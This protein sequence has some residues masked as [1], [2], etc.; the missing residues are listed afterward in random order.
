MEGKIKNRDGSFLTGCTTCGKSLHFLYDT[1]AGRIVLKLLTRRF[2]SKLTGVY[3][4]SR[5]S[6]LNIKSAIKSCGIDLSEYELTDY[7]QFSCYNDFFTRRIKKE[8]RPLSSEP[9]VF[10]SPCDSKLTVYPV[11]EDSCFFIK[12][13]AYT[14][15]DLVGGNQALADQYKGGYCLIFRL[16]VDNYHRYCYIDNGK[17]DENIF[18]PGVLHT[19][20]P[21]ALGRYNIYKRNC[22]E[23]TVLHTENFDDVVQIEVGAMMVGRI[24]NHHGA[25]AFKKGEEKGMF[26][27]GGSTI[28]L[29]VKKDI[30]TIDS[31]IVANSTENIETTVK[32][33]ERIAVRKQY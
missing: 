7:R 23:Y 2:L 22:R 12:S 31:D 25:H 4:N 1:A 24:K 19:V 30:L 21:I 28:V 9:D 8:N 14:V 32:I 18:V 15:C 20:N 17:K 3:M 10:I 5:I 33:G 16:T 13:S 11:N 6:K 29:L 27:F 26:E